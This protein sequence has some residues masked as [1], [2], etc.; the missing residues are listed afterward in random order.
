MLWRRPLTVIYAGLSRLAQGGTE[1]KE[2]RARARAR[3]HPYA[4][5]TTTTSI[6]DTIIFTHEVVEVAEGPLWLHTAAT[7]ISAR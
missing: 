7:A 4:H 1:V 2:L 5:A 3:A 6:N